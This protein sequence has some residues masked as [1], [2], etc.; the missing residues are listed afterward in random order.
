MPESITWSS[1]TARQILDS[2]PKGLMYGLDIMEAGF[3]MMRM[4]F[5]QVK[6][7]EIYDKLKDCSK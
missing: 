4:L 7:L 5:P 2:S 6:L 3:M 1:A